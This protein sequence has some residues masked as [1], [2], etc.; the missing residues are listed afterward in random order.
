MKRRIRACAGVMTALALVGCG[1]SQDLGSV[2]GSRA[3]GIGIEARQDVP[4]SD[5]PLGDVVLGT[6]RAGDTVW[7]VC[8]VDGAQTNAGVSGSAVKIESA[9]L[10]GYAAVTS[11]SADPADRERLFDT[12]QDAL[13]GGLAC[14]SDE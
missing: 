4:V 5:K 9:G 6:L 3:D 11:M 14:C 10:S 7:A 1:P 12:D 8:Y 13:R 2:S